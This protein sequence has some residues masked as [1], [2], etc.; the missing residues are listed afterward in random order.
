MVDANGLNCGIQ[1]ASEDKTTRSSLVAG[2]WRAQVHW[3]D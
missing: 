1:N 2:V 3:V